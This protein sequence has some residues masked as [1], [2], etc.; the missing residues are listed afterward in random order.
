MSRPS[1]AWAGERGHID[2][3]L[4]DRC[5]PRERLALQ[6]LVRAGEQTTASIARSLRGLGV[7]ADHTHHEQFGMA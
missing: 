7:P 5:L 2:T 1:E 4:L 6:Y 3:A